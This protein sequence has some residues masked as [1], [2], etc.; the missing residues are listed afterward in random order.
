VT[1][2]ARLRSQPRGRD[3]LRPLNPRRDMTAVATVIERSF[4][5]QL[6][7]NSRRMIRQ[8][9]ALG[10]FGWLG[11]VVAQLIL[12]PAAYPLGFVWEE[13]GSVVGNA[14][15][16]P[17]DRTSSRWMLANVAVLPEQRRRGIAHAMVAASIDL[18]ARHGARELVL[19]VDVRSDAAHKLYESLGFG[20]Q[21]TR[22]TWWR[23]AET[24]L[25]EI[26]SDSPIRQRREEDWPQEYALARS[27]FPEGLRW[28][29]PLTADVFRPEP[30]ARALGI[31]RARHW[32]WY[33]DSEKVGAALAAQLEAEARH[34]RFTLMVPAELHDI[35]D[36]PLL[37]HGLH[38]LKAAQ[39]PA[40]LDHPTG[41]ATQALMSLGFR[42]ER[43]LTWMRLDLRSSG[44]Q[45]A[46]G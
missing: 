26:S 41:L 4:A 29:M 2:A 3:G 27:L 39:L 6:D 11:W 1:A 24:R 17:T 12:P 46:G 34:W 43:S 30:F 28:P 44:E 5:G 25:P 13:G 20:T 18:A 8:M 45:S 23:P 16:L 14:S 7:A 10:R 32:V 37:L 38:A 22:T 31:K 33:D 36:G 19:Q 21:T 40:T 42:P 15:L 9:K 35:A